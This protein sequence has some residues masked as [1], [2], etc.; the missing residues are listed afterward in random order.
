MHCEPECRC[1]EI[2]E[3]RVIRLGRAEDND[4]VV[5]HPMVSGHHADIY[6]FD[7]GAIQYMDH[8]TNGTM[9]D[10]NFVR[11]SSFLLTGGER[12]VLPGDVSLDVSQLIASPSRTDTSMIDDRSVEVPMPQEDMSETPVEGG[13]SQGKSSRGGA[14]GSPEMF[15]NMFSFSG[16][17]RRLEYNIVN[18]GISLF[19]TILSSIMESMEFP[20]VGLFIVL[21]CAVPLAWLQYAEGAKRCH[22]LG[23]S[24]WFQIIPFYPLAMM[25]GDG[26]S[27]DNEYGANPKGK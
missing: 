24:G 9:I 27:G 5:S 10:G 4:V 6:V 2:K 18:F 13:V 11:N 23:H 26:D 1:L 7:N 16:R 21:L 20:S 14:A 3:M 15:S 12:L 17:I 8:S 19:Y 25:F 22:D